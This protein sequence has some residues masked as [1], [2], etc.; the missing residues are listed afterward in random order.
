MSPSDAA[1][2]LGVAAAFD[3]RTVGES[4]AR[5]WAEV[6]G[7]CPLAD[8]VEAVK[9]H[10]A[11]SREFI[12]PS[13]ISHHVKAVRAERVRAAGDLTARMPDA[14]DSI[15]D[16][17][18]HDAAYR[19]WLS[20]ARRRVGNG[21]PVDSVAPPPALNPAEA[22]KVERMVGELAASLSGKRPAPKCAS[23]GNDREHLVHGGTGREN[24][25][26]FQPATD[27]RRH[28]NEP[29]HNQ[30]ESHG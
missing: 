16:P 23:C 20:E 8:A 14:I 26:E 10:Y 30:E 4:D 5:A 7:A 21:E 3:R 28:V 19:G 27:L 2:V 24:D 17:A 9:A 22:E 13:D 1:I 12:Y 18:Q 15:E 25:H 29:A 11:T 6:L